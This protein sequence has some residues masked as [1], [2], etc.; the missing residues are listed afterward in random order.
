MTT[1]CILLNVF[2]I[3]LSKSF[4]WMW[5]KF[6]SLGNER[7][8]LWG[9]LIFEH[10]LE[11]IRF[12]ESVCDEVWWMKKA[13]R[14][15]DTRSNLETA[16]CFGFLVSLGKTWS[17]FLLEQE[18]SSAPFLDWWKDSKKEALQKCYHLKYRR[19]YTKFSTGRAV[20]CNNN[21]NLLTCIKCLPDN[22][23]SAFCV[24]IISIYHPYSRDIEAK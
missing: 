3:K 23:Q 17:S 21:S 10:V 11:S 1:T 19:Q 16:T 14:S 20:S 9:H 8:S 15:N 7:W 4:L 18:G 6:F 12:A 24:M 2:I 22:V 5:G 13:K